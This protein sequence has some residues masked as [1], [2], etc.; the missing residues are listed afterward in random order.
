MTVLP[1]QIPVLSYC[2]QVIGQNEQK[3][4]KERE[5]RVSQ[6]ASTIVD[7]DDIETAISEQLSEEE[8]L[9]IIDINP[10]ELDNIVL[11]E[12]ANDN[13]AEWTWNY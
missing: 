10:L 7:L 8:D 13:A 3:F 6:P 2:V 5:P 1:I 4:R 9:D 11:T 12:T